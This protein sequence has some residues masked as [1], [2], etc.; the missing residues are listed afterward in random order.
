MGDCS[1]LQSLLSIDAPLAV[2]EGACA[3]LLSLLFFV[4]SPPQL[5]PVLSPSPSPSPPRCSLCLMDFTPTHSARCLECCGCSAHQLCLVS[6]LRTRIEHK[7][8]RCRSFLTHNFAAAVLAEQAARVAE[9]RRR[10][11]LLDR[12]LKRVLA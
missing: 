12:A 6:L 3:D 8:G 4:D 10:R 5:P 1:V 9:E 7:C 2:D 11:R